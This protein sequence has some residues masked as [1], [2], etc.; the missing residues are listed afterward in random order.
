MS[1]ITE[2][3]NINADYPKIFSCLLQII[4]T[5]EDTCRLKLLP[6]HFSTN[7]RNDNNMHGICDTI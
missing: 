6:P 4:V 7:N 3:Q 2:Q 5:K 1:L